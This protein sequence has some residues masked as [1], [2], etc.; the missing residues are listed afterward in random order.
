MIAACENSVGV[1]NRSGISFLR[2]VQYGVLIACDHAPLPRT[3]YKIS[4][5]TQPGT[6]V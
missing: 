4:I 2:H 5:N 1:P 3:Y 6:M